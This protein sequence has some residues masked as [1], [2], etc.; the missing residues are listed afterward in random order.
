M[1]RRTFAVVAS[2]VLATCLL[3]GCRLLNTTYPNPNRY[4]LAQWELADAVDDIDA[5]EI[6][7]GSGALDLIAASGDAFTFNETASE[8]VRQ[9]AKAYTWVEDK[10]LHVAYTTPNYDAMPEVFAKRLVIGVPKGIS[11]KR[12]A[13]DASN[14]EVRLDELDANEVAVR[15]SSGTMQVRSSAKQVDLQASSGSIHADLR[16]CEHAT[17]QTSSGDVDVS[18]RDVENLVAEASAG[19]CS[20]DLQ[21]VPKNTRAQTSAG[22]LH[23]RTPKNCDLY[24]TVDTA[25]GKFVTHV[26]FTQEG[27]D[28]YLLGKGKNRLT[29][30]SGAG[31]T[32]IEYR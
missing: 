21:T 11:L 24:A 32:H 5:I 7:Y 19:T 2:L 14:T 26:P 27:E 16:N 9:D 18:A 15:T 29:A 28:G 22:D 17:A 13:V 23:V 1:Q 3:A 25:S 10:T 31:D 12:L 20:V 6:A 8:E 4:K 30:Q